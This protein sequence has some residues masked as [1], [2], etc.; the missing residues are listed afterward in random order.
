[1]VIVRSALQ[2]LRKWSRSPRIWVLALLLLVFANN[3]ARTLCQAAEESGK[4]LSPWLLPFLLQ[5]RYLQFC[6][7]LCLVGLFCDAPFLDPLQ[8]YVLLRIGRTR[9]ML[10]QFLYIATASAL[11]F[12]FLWGAMLLR[13]L[14]VLSWTVS[15]GPCLTMLAHDNPFFG[16]PFSADLIL[17]Q[18]AVRV[19][20]RTFLMGWLTG[21]FLGGLLVYLNLNL[22]RE[23]G[24]LAAGAVCVLDFVLYSYMD[25]LPELFWLSPVSWMNP[26]QYTIGTGWK[27]P[28]RA[29][30][31]LLLF[32][33]LCLLSI[34]KLRRR[35]IET[36]PQI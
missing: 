2:N 8:P 17:G 31:L 19:F 32:V 10:G 4:A 18:N 23:T 6:T 20:A 35:Q 12:L 14:R 15:W 33:L 29:G 5:D 27:W 21:C 24:A 28:V 34:Q 7:A 26:H 13:C 3:P 1:M 22:R 36:L 11:F 9:W 25:T 16:V 30:I